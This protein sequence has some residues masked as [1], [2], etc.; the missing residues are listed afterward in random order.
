M[1]ER[2]KKFS[3]KKTAKAEKR[4][5]PEDADE[6]VEAATEQEEKFWWEFFERKDA[7]DKDLEEC[8]D[9]RANDTAQRTTKKQ[10]QTKLQEKLRGMAKMARQDSDDPTPNELA[11]LKRWYLRATEEHATTEQKE[12][13]EIWA[14]GEG[15]N[16]PEEPKVSAG[17]KARTEPHETRTTPLRR[18]VTCAVN[19]GCRTPRTVRRWLDSK[20]GQDIDGIVIEKIEDGWLEGWDQIANGS[21]KAKVT[22]RGP[23]K[24]CVYR[25][26]KMLQE[27]PR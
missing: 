12:Q 14:S 17:E 10:E 4:H 22:L 1:D 15:P 8:T 27:A 9:T 7:L 3:T 5:E 24:D 2:R 11:L 23:L 25:V 16:L 13:H 26:K 6:G 21:V 18:L 20:I 19:E